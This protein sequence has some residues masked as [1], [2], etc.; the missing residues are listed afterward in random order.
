MPH[1][2][3]FA[4][5]PPS[6]SSFRRKL[7][8]LPRFGCVIRPPTSFP[9]AEVSGRAAW[10]ALGLAGSPPGLCTRCT[11]RPC[12]SPDLS[13][14]APSC[15]APAPRWSIW[16]FLSTCDV[17]GAGPRPE[18]DKALPSERLLPAVGHFGPKHK[19]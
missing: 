6:P 3:L 15:R 8:T 11:S 17:L 2:H 7:P 10:R 16:Y 5:A 4:P 12:P 19:I 1:P 18:S 14:Q 13:L 9:Q